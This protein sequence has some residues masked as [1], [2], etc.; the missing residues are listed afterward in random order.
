MKLSNTKI[1]AAVCAM[2]FFALV[3]SSRKY[4][5]TRVEGMLSR[6]KNSEC[7]SRRHG[8]RKRKSMPL[9]FRIYTEKQEYSLSGRIPIMLA[10]R[11]ISNEDYYIKTGFLMED[12][13]FSTHKV[14]IGKLIH[15]SIF[16]RPNFQAKDNYSLLKKNESKTIEF[17]FSRLYTVKP[18]GKYE[19]K[20][21]YGNCSEGDRHTLVPIWKFWATQHKAWTGEIES[22]PIPIIFVK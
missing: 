16:I 5:D 4:D 11:N 18:V 22:N 8:D 6:M 2:C 21:R 10:F 20:V 17:E 7:M 19:I 9:E 14:S 13:S 15:K 1:V 3:F 12:L